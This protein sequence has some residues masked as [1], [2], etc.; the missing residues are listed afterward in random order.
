[1]RFVEFRQRIY[2]LDEGFVPE[3]VGTP[4]DLVTTMYLRSSP[5]AEH[6]MKCCDLK[7]CKQCDEFIDGRCDYLADQTCVADDRFCYGFKWKEE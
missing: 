5:N 3:N 2:S 7:D 1:M 6:N 4:D